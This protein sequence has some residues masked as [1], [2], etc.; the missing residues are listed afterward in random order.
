[1]YRCYVY[2]V[3]VTC[4]CDPIVIYKFLLTGWLPD[5]IHVLY[6]NLHDLAEVYFDLIFIFKLFQST[7]VINS[8]NPTN[9]ILM[10]YV[11]LVDRSKVVAQYNPWWHRYNTGLDLLWC[12][13]RFFHPTP[14]DTCID[15]ANEG[16]CHWG[17][18]TRCHCCSVWC[19]V[20]CVL[21]A[22]VYPPKIVPFLSL[23]FPSYSYRKN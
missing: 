9:F 2:S 3:L 10:W 7:C 23:P 1:M 18:V 22:C 6:Y 16:P 8:K 21:C 13:S 14:F 20:L 12:M 11:F 19:M 15:R 5:V 17:T 4:I